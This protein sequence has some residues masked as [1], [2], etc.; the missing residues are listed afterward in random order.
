MSSHFRFG[1]LDLFCESLVSAVLNI[2]CVVGSW[3][4][5]RAAGLVCFDF[6]SLCF[7][8]DRGLGKLYV[9]LFHLFGYISSVFLGYFGPV[10]S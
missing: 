9:F 4:E 6:F 5:G 10:S 8:V 3:A 2:V 7:C 1:C